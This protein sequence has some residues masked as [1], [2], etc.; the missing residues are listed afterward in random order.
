MLQRVVRSVYAAKS[1]FECTFQLQ[2]CCSLLWVYFRTFFFC[3]E[4]TNC[5]SLHFRD[6]AGWW[7]AGDVARAALNVRVIVFQPRNEQNRG[8]QSVM[9]RSVGKNI[10]T[11]IWT[12]FDCIQRRAIKDFRRFPNVRGCALW[13]CPYFGATSNGTASKNAGK[14]HS[15]TFRTVIWAIFWKYSAFIGLQSHVKSRCK[16]PRCLTGQTWQLKS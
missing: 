16:H 11:W 2:S 4:A 7:S 9:K 12:D 15:T 10:Y 6:A 3:Q 5:R 13:I 1:K 14:L 8:M